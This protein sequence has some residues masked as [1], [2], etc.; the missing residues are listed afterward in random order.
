MV[1]EL[2]LPAYP[3]PTKSGASCDTISGAKR[4]AEFAFEQQ[5]GL[6]GYARDLLPLRILTTSV[7]ICTLRFLHTAEKMAACMY[8]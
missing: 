1:R 8:A 6:F 7:S 5:S 2:R 4:E 3:D